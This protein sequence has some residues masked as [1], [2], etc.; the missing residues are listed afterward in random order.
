MRNDTHMD[1]MD[2]LLFSIADEADAFVDYEALKEAIEEKRAEK[3]K[4]K[5]LWLR[6]GPVAAV[7]TVGLMAGLVFLRAELGL[8]G[9]NTAS[10]M[11][12]EARY[13]CSESA[14][15]NASIT[16]ATLAPEDALQNAEPDDTGAPLT[17][18]GDRNDESGDTGTIYSV[19]ERSGLTLIPAALSGSAA[20]LRVHPDGSVE[21]IFSDGRTFTASYG[22]VQD[23]GGSLLAGQYRIEAQDDET[24][25]HISY[26]ADPSTLILIETQGFTADEVRAAIET[27]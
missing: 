19:R 27:W 12:K 14:Q 22:A 17:G 23:A 16:A 7:L 18:Q 21:L 25:L 9:S 3:R 15:D 5:N 26:L 20:D 8:G 24:R 11:Q 13:G 6:F 1:K 4:R 2:E 10:P